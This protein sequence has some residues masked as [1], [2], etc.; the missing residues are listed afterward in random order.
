[1]PRLS[2]L[3]YL[4]PR[5]DIEMAGINPYS[6]NPNQMANQM[7]DNMTS[8]Q[9]MMPVSNNPIAAQ[10]VGSRSILQSQQAIQNQQVYGGLAG[11]PMTSVNNSPGGIIANQ[12]RSRSS[13]V[14]PAVTTAQAQQQSGLQLQLQKGIQ[15]AQ[16]SMN[17]SPKMTVY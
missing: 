14:S 10:P 5:W 1:M 9:N 17:A 6:L 3:A 8:T 12:M 16:A 13:T 2:A 7:Q 15:P 11:Q 4:T